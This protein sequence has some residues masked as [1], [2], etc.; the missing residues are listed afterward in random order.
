MSSHR[1]EDPTT[2]FRQFLHTLSRIPQTTSPEHL[3]RLEKLQGN[4]LNDAKLL[5][6]VDIAKRERLVKEYEDEYKKSAKQSQ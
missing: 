5:T 3:A 1:A 4:L 2:L 6:E